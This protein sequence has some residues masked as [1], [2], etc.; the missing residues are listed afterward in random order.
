M[1]FVY[2][3]YILQH[4]WI[5]KNYSKESVSF[6]GVS[7]HVIKSFANIVFPFKC[8]YLLVNLLFI[9]PNCPVYWAEY[10][11]LQNSCPPAPPNVIMFGNKTFANITGWIRWRHSAL[12]KILKP[13]VGVLAKK[14]MWRDTNTETGEITTR[15]GRKKLEWSGCKTR[16]IKIAG[17]YQKWE[18]GKGSSPTVFRVSMTLPTS[19]RLAS[20]IVREYI[21]VILSHSIC[22]TLL[23]KTWEVN[24]S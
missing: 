15:R 4:F 22:D 9:L 7:K 1:I 11:L 21:H 6:L 20:L 13:R 14:A 23:W 5:F 17:N 12:E 24:A 18:R 3:I 8:G 19:W 16:T 10:V 2:W